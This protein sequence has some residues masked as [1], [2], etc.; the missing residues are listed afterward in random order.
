MEDGR[1]LI[2]KG[3][4]LKRYQSYRRSVQKDNSSSDVQTIDMDKVDSL[5]HCHG[6]GQTLGS[7]GRGR[8]RD[9]SLTSYLHQETVI[10]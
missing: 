8:W 9:Q 5:C 6:H 3:F 2:T 7:I 1:A 10:D 4:A